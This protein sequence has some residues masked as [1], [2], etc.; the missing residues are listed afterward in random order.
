VGHRETQLVVELSPKDKG[1]EGHLETQY[2]DLGSDQAVPT[3]PEQ[4]V[5]TT[6]YRVVLSAYMLGGHTLKHL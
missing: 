3:A 2:F 1:S 6:H 5:A 4:L